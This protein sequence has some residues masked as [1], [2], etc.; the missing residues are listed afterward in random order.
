MSF[1]ISGRLE[2]AFAI[3]DLR[4][5]A[6]LRAGVRIFN[7]RDLLAIVVGVSGGVAE[8]IGLRQLVSSGVIGKD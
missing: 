5:R 6:L 3:I 1:G 8:W 7:G 4:R 2:I